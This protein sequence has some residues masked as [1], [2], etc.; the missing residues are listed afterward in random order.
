M[1]SP[2]QSEM[3][4]NSPKRSSANTAGQQLSVC[5][6]FLHSYKLQVL[7]ACSQGC[8]GHG[9][10]I[11]VFVNCTRSLLR[12][13]RPPLFDLVDFIISA[14]IIYLKS[15]NPLLKDSITMSHKY[16]NL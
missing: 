1:T 6:D 2:P 14:L 15:E 10:E 8:K 9:N 3:K 12:K 11:N 7:I 16:F 4:A 5:F 13:R